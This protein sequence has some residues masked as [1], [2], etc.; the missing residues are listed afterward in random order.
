MK[1][2]AGCLLVAYDTNC[3][4][5]Y[6]FQVDIPQT[7]PKRTVMARQTGH[8]RAVT[9]RLISN[10]QKVTTTLA[11]YAELRDCIYG[12][13]EAR[14]TDREVEAQLGCAQN[15]KIP[16]QLKLRVQLAVERHA[17]KLE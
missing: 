6:C 5:Y 17:T 4:V 8:A 1:R 10:Q 12:A 11:A 9:E 13:V 15:E 2:L 16:D 14:M 7:N 3:L